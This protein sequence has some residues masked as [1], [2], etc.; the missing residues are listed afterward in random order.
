MTAIFPAAAYGWTLLV[1]LALIGVV[2]GL[3][4]LFAKR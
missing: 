3:V 4:L 2:A 1:T